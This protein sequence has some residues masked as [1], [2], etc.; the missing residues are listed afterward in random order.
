MLLIKNITVCDGT[1][2]EGYISDILLDGDRIAEIR[3]GINNQALSLGFN[4]YRSPQPLVFRI[5]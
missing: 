3:P 1:G 2:S 5:V 4:H